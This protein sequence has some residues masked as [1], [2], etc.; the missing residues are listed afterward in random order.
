MRRS[1]ILLVLI[2]VLA[3]GCTP[4]VMT[5]DV[6]EHGVK[7]Y[8]IPA[9]TPIEPAPEEVR[10]I[11]GLTPGRLYLNEEGILTMAPEL[12][13]FTLPRVT[14]ARCPMGA[15][16]ILVAHYV[17]PPVIRL[18]VRN[19]GGTSVTVTAQRWWAYRYRG[20]DMDI[21]L[22][23]ILEPRPV[24]YIDG[25]ECGQGYSQTITF[26][27]RRRVHV[28]VWG[29]WRVFAREFPDG[30][31]EEITGPPLWSVKYI[32]LVPAVGK[33]EVTRPTLWGE[34]Q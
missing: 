15:A 5:P 23:Y 6:P 30:Q 20:S 28:E 31:W 26:G 19:A 12:R 25:K 4:P 32:Q 11:L 9:A 34:T 27:Q 33:R 18:G 8:N 10:R 2:G 16:A 22:R 29:H 13:Q 21:E 14:F 7:P 3:I 1:S 24:W 17:T